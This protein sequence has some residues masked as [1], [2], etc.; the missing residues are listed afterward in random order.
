MEIGII[1]YGRFGRFA[2]AILKRHFEVSFYDRRIRTPD[3]GVRFLPLSETAR[4]PVLVLCVPI[5]QIETVCLQL[6]PYLAPGQLV[7]DACSVK[8]KP[9]RIMKRILPRAVQV[10]GTHPLFGPDSARKGIEGHRIVLCPGRG[11]QLKKVER[12]LK[13]LGLEVIITTA[14]KHDRQMAHSQALFHFLAR[15]VAMLKIKLGR[16]SNPGPSRM[17]AEFQDVQNDSPQLF[18]DMQRENPFSA[19]FRRKLIENL[20]R[21]D[22]E[23]KRTREQPLRVRGLGV[24]HRR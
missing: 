8:Q 7:L 4:K 3:E 1:G 5:S 2:G 6:R 17:F 9:I 23:L 20:I 24:G 16:I 14:A 10:L 21:V 13:S 18:R 22:Q 19:P 11:F 15:G 12:Y